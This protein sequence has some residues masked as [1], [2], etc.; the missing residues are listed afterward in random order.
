[1]TPE[2]VVFD[3]G[4]V[5]IE[6]NPERFYDREIGEA[7]RL[8][9]FAEVDLH[10]MNLAVDAGA[11]FAA[12][13]A[14]LAARHPEWAPQILWWHDRWTET[15]TPRIEHSISLLRALRAKGVPVFALTNFAVETFAIATARIDFFSEFDRS[16]V[17]G[18]L[19]LI[20]PDP[21]IYAH[22]EAQTGIAPEGLFFTDDKAANTKAAARRGWQTHPFTGAE[23]LARRLTDLG[24]LTEA[25][26]TS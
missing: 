12:S 6:W 9:L 3:I 26:A 11:P 10:G 8:R 16:F 14:A 24:L 2:A 25:E 23:G 13:V 19:G 15:L 17:S 18:H 5:L 21:A 4:N 22:V 7:A 1:M 20:K